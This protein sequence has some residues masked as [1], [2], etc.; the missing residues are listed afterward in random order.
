MASIHNE[1]SAIPVAVGPLIGSIRT[2]T[3][4]R[5]SSIIDE[6]DT[7]NSGET[8]NNNDTTIQNPQTTSSVGTEEATTIDSPQPSRRSLRSIGSSINGRSTNGVR[9]YFS[10]LFRRGNNR[11]TGG[12]SSDDEL[13]TT[14]IDMMIEE[15]EE[16]EE[17]EQ[18]QQKQEQRA[19]AGRTSSLAKV[20]STNSSGAKNKYVSR[21]HIQLANGGEMHLETV[22]ALMERGAV[23]ARNKI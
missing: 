20:D 10:N 15:G 4:D 17:S 3:A 1:N 8:T 6:Q 22:T 18:S 16:E 14:Q 21:N 13:A 5:V 2:A 23:P 7:E 19:S 12:G 11:K 9:A